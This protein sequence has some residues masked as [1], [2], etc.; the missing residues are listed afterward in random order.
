VS[1]VAIL[2]LAGD[3]MLGREVGLRLATEPFDRVFARPCAS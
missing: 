2:A 3:A 1:V